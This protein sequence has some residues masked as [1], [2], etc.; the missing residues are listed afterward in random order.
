MAV[1]NE[2]ATTVG[3]NSETWSEYIA[4]FS[5]FILG[6]Q[7]T[8]RYGFE[9]VLK[10][11]S[12]VKSY[13]IQ[14]HFPANG[15]LWNITLYL[16]DGT[17]NISPESMQEISDTFD[18]SSTENGY[19]PPGINIEYSAPEIIF[20]DISVIIYV[21]K[22]IQLD[23]IESSTM[24]KIIERQIEEYISSFPIGKSYLE[25]DLIV[26]IKKT[27]FVFDVRVEAPYGNL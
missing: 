20:M 23:E 1:S 5:D 2:L 24:I 13:Y 16:E 6:L 21:K 14:E 17:G 19:R 22:G 11:S 26:E 8:N 15:N 9:S 4:R 25:S 18:G 12:L 10:E 27:S 3:T 7:R